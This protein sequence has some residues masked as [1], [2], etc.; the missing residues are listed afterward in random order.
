MIGRLIELAW[1]AAAGSFLV[2]VWACV[3]LTRWHHREE[4]DAAKTEEVLGSLLHDRSHQYEQ[5]TL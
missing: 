1:C 3:L 2:F 4:R 5:D